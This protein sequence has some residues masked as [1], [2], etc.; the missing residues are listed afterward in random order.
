MLLTLFITL[1]LLNNVSAEIDEICPMAPN[2][3]PK[4][5]SDELKLYFYI[6]IYYNNFLPN[7][8]DVL[9]QNGNLVECISI[10]KFNHDYDLNIYAFATIFYLNENLYAIS[11]IKEK[12]SGLLYENNLSWFFLDANLN[13]R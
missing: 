3:F 6:S 1:F 11:F 7:S 13:K 12:I 5:Y 4:N 9:D 2:I 10:D 8:I